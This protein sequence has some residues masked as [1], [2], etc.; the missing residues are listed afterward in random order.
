MA[1]TDLPRGY[2]QTALARPEGAE[3]DL[4]RDLTA[5]LRARGVALSDGAE[6]PDESVEAEPG[7]SDSLAAGASSEP[8]V[9]ASVS[10]FQL[11]RLLAA[12]GSHP[13][14]I[15]AF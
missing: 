4:Y 14:T 2:A 1:T 5:F 11:S 10:R 15:A 12:Q 3:A 8:G 6:P 7:P 9:A 13:A